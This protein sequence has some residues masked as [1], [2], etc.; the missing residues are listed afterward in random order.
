MAKDIIY[1]P[2][3]KHV[4]PYGFFPSFLHRNEH[5]TRSESAQKNVRSSQHV[6]RKSFVDLREEPTHRK[7]VW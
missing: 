2:V 1:E 4:H 6:M 5:D 3:Q 7:R